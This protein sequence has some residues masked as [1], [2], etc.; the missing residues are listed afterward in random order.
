MIL[1]RENKFVACKPTSFNGFVI[2][3]SKN[4]KKLTSPVLVMQLR[5]FVYR[6]K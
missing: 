5:N 1:N 6:N 4:D 2:P 3:E